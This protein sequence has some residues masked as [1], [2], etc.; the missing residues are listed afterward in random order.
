[1]HAGGRNF[2]NETIRLMMAHAN[3]YADMSIVNSVSPQAIHMAGLEAFRDAG[4]LDRIMFGSDNEPFGPIVE[5]IEAVTFLTEEERRAIY[6]ENAARFHGN[7]V[8]DQIDGAQCVAHD[9]Q[10]H[11]LGIPWHTRVLSGEVESIGLRLQFPNM[12]SP[13]PSPPVGHYAPTLRFPLVSA[14]E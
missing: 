2:L 3:V 7:E 10:Q 9:E 6:C 12:F 1:M 4:V 11:G 8:R 14:C 5:R 13:A